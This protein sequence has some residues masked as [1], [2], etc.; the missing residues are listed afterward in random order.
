[1]T[2]PA[3]CY[4]RK[5]GCRRARP[6]CRRTDNPRNVTC[7][8]GSYHYPHRLGSGRC[9]AHLQGRDRMNELAWG[10]SASPRSPCS[11]CQEFLLPEQLIPC[12]A[13]GPDCHLCH[14]CLQRAWEA[15]EEPDRAV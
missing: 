2:I 6:L 8:C 12:Q 9:L 10:P 14:W 3:R 7:N 15:Q 1:M 11:D 13:F 5:P 4:C